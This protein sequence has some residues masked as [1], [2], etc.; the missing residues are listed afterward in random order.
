[1]LNPWSRFPA[2]RLS[3][4][5]IAGVAGHILFPYQVIAAGILLI[6]AAACILVWV[7]QKRFW[8]KKISLFLPGVCACF[9]VACLAYLLTFLH[10]DLV[11]PHHFS[12]HLAPKSLLVG[13]IK[14]PPIEKEKTYRSIVEIKKVISP[15]GKERTVKGKLLVS[16]WKGKQSEKLKYG[17]LLLLPAKMVEIEPPKNPEQFNYKE[18]MGFQNIHH[19]LFVS[20]DEWK[21]LAQHCGNQFFELVFAWRDLLFQQISTYV[22]TS[23]ELGVASALV[24]GYKDFIT[25]EVTQAYAA[26]GA[27]HVLCVSGLHV[28]MIFVMLSKL[29]F[30]LNKNT[31]TRLLQTALI[32][33]FI[34]IYACMTGL[35]P[36]VMRAATMFSLMAL[37]KQ[38]SQRSNIFNIIGASA[39]LL[40]VLHPYIMTEVGFKLSYLAVLG[41]V[42]L[43]PMI[44][45]WWHVKHWLLQN[46]WEITAVSIA[47]Q[48]ATFPV[49]LYYF[50]QFPNWFLISNLVVIPAAW[51]LIN[52][53]VALF[54]SSPFPILQIW[55]GKLFYW[56]IWLLNKFIFFID[57]LP[58][59]I[60]QGVSISWIELLIIYYMVLLAADMM[61]ELKPR[62]LILFLS[63]TLC[64]AGWNGYETL[65]QSKQQNVVCYSVKN[66]KALAIIQGNT[67]FIDFDSSLLKNQSAMLFH[68]KHHW[69]KHG[70]KNIL[71]IN[72][73]PGYIPLGKDYAFELKNHRFWM[74]Q[75]ESTPRQ[76]SGVPLKFDVAILSRN[77]PVSL[78]KKWNQAQAFTIVSD[79]TIKPYRRENFQRFAQKMGAK[80]IDVTQTGAVVW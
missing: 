1:V 65:A 56:L 16:F 63:L 41:I 64:L 39:L 71:P 20:D 29:L 9:M 26:S 68:I 76:Q 77:A 34:W 6:I 42:Y 60:L 66:H 11:S 25:P 61:V 18:F 23:A 45:R 27:L 72:H 59:S 69:W 8:L 19:Q 62:S 54:I 48:A 74:V 79:G 43:Q 70:I 38:F 75:S 17:T 40:M 5:F 7:R 3:L 67:A 78:D 14:Q 13:I 47:A 31:K 50:H 44:A 52:L 12:A 2:V 37:G 10:T 55:I 35:S 80:F 24:L 30:F 53:G 21:F 46:I 33:C 36:S 15:S 51:V 49:G 73:F 32:V 58:Y 4:L 57:D 22:K 28:G